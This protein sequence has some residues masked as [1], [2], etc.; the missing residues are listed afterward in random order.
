MIVTVD[1]CEICEQFTAESVYDD[2]IRF[3]ISDPSFVPIV[4]LPKLGITVF[5]IIHSPYM[6]HCKTLE[7]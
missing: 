4:L 1:S 2:F 3:A 5:S 6:P 7:L